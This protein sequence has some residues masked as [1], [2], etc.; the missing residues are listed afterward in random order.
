MQLPTGLTDAQAKQPQ[1]AATAGDVQQ[2]AQRRPG[3]RGVYAI[4][5]G[6]A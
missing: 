5:G 2:R 3:V 4:D 1:P 6:R